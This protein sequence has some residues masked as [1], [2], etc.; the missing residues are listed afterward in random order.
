M[1]GIV[2]D[3]DITIRAVA[4]GFDPNKTKISEV[5]TRVVISCTENT[6]VFEAA[7]IMEANKIRRLLVKNEKGEMTGILSLGDIAVSSNKDFVSDILQDIDK[8]RINH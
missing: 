1:R 2:T 3:R 8:S 6:P 4:L 5:M 7:R